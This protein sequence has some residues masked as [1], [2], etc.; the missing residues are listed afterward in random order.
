MSKLA[1]ILPAICLRMLY[2]CENV[3]GYFNREPPPSSIIELRN[4]RVRRLY[5]PAMVHPPD[6]GIISPVRARRPLSYLY[7]ALLKDNTHYFPYYHCI[8]I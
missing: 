7:V 1:L 6:H 5:N 2:G 8:V 4:H 3:S